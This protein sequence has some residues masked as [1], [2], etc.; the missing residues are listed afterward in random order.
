MF[1]IVLLLCYGCGNVL[2]SCYDCDMFVLLCYYGV[3]VVLLWWWCVMLRVAPVL[4]A[5]CYVIVVWPLR[6]Y[7]GDAYVR[8]TIVF[9]IVLL[10][11]HCVTIVLLWW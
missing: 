4:F 6:Y 1:C 11:Y 5:C 9:L 2:C 7:G 8:A 3:M 10:C